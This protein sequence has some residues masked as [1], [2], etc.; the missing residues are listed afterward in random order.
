MARV[1]VFALVSLLVIGGVFFGIAYLFFSRFPRR[2]G[3]EDPRA[4]Q[5]RQKLF[6]QPHQHMAVFH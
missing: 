3:H 2:G 4:F 6:L 5:R 1:F